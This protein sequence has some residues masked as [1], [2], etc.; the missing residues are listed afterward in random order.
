ML[1]SAAVM[2][3]TTISVPARMFEL[4]YMHACM[5]NVS[6]QKSLKGSIPGKD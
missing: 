2:S 5:V 1:N 6:H 4:A 3:E